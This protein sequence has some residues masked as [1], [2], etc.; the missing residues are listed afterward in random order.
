LDFADSLIADN[1]AILAA[2]VEEAKLLAAQ[3]GPREQ[4]IRIEGGLPEL[5]GTNVI[6]PHEM[7]GHVIQAIESTALGA[8][9]SVSASEVRGSSSPDS[10]DAQAQLPRD[11]NGETPP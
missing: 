1:K 7:N 6:M 5:P 10:A 11:S 9:P 3:G 8:S 2:L 4:T